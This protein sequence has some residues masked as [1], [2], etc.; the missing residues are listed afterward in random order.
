[1]EKILLVSANFIKNISNIS[2]NIS[3]KVIEP[4]IYEAK[5]EG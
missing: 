3:G 5:N 4:A 2:D 1:M